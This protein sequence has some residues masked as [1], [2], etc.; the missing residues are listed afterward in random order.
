MDDERFFGTASDFLKM[1]LHESN[2]PSNTILVLRIFQ[3]ML[4]KHRQEKNTKDFL[5]TDLQRINFAFQ[6]STNPEKDELYIK[7]LENLL[8][9]CSDYPDI[10][11]EVKFRMAQAIYTRGNN[12]SKKTN[13]KKPLGL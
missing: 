6:K 11:G 3:D 4:Q 13:E 12:F 9:E 1:N 2:S 5:L 8:S 10:H 7:A